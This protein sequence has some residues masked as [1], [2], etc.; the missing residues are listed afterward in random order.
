MKTEKLSGKI[1]NAYGS[2]LATPVPYDGTVEIYET[3]A[4][5]EAAKE[6]PSND[7]TVSFVNQKRKA[8]K[9]QALMSAALEAAGIKKPTLEDPQV[10][11]STIVKA[12]VAAGKSDGEAKAI[13][14][15]SLG[16]SF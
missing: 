1:E 2:A 14:N 3:Y 4:E 10:Q 7:E 5:V 9:R 13:A 8:A 15:A 6:L 11:F 12:L 16:T